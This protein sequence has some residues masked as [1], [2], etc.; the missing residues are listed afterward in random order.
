LKCIAKNIFKVLHTIFKIFQWL[1]IIVAVS[2]IIAYICGIRLYVVTTG[3][4]SPTIPVG[5]ICFV[6]HNIPYDSIMTG[7]IISFRIGENTQVTHRVTAVESD[8]FTTQGDA[9]NVEDAMK[10]NRQNYLGKTIFYIPDAG[11]IIY[12][13]KTKTGTIIFS[14]FV[15]IMLICSFIC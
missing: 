8:G 7:D 11:F 2:L 15:L 3:S 14:G 10:V 1:L 4:M 13:L 12:F 5:S 9:N 6:N